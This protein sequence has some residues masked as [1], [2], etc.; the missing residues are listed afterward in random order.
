MANPSGRI[1]ASKHG[2][3]HVLE[4]VGRPV[5][6]EF[7]RLDQEKLQAAKAEFLQMERD[8]II[9]RSRS[10]WAS[11]LHMVRKADGSWRPCGDYRQLNLATVADKY[12]VPNMQDLSARLHGRAIFIKLGLRKGYYQ[13]PMRPEDVAKTAVITPFGLWE[14]LRMPF[15]LK[16][17]GQTFQQLMDRLGA[18][19]DFV[20][21]YLDDILVASPDVETHKQH[22]HTIL[23]RLRQFG[24]VL[25]LEKCELGRQSVDFLGHRITAAGVAPLLKHVAAVRDYGRPMDM[26]SLQSF[27]GLVNFYGRFVPAPPRYSGRLQTLYAVRGKS[28]W[29]GSPAWRPLSTKLYRRYVTPRAC[30]TQTQRPHSAWR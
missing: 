10:S 21:I 8:G 11:P 27:L 20:F 18:D 12:L 14:F 19:L 26:R 4:T 30:H 13:I 9:C 2:V 1:P 23:Q 28:I 6:A 29:C 24:L 5:T 16:N 25:N 3:E 22:L 7:R 17:A 15:G